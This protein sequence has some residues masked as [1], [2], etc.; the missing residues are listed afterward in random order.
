[1]FRN[2]ADFEKTV[3][4]LNIDSKPN[5]AHRESLRREMLSAFGKNERQPHQQMT[6]LG[7][8]RRTIMKSPIS[9]I[10]AAV[11]IIAVLIGINQFGG[12]VDIATIAFADITEAMQ[13]VTWMRVLPDE[14]IG[15]QALSGEY[16]YSHKNKI[17]ATKDTD[18][19]VEYF[20]LAAQKKYVYKPKT[21]T[22]TIST[23]FSDDDSDIMSRSETPFG[24][25]ETLVETL[26]KLGADVEVEKGKY[27]GTDVYI[28]SMTSTVENTLPFSVVKLFVDQQTH[29][30]LRMEMHLKKA[31]E[32]ADGLHEKP[33][34]MPDRIVSCFEYPENGPKDIY[35]LGVPKTARIVD[36]TISGQTQK[37]LDLYLAC[38]ENL[39]KRYILLITSTNRY[40]DIDQTELSYNDEPRQRYEKI[41]VLDMQKWSKSKGAATAINN[42]N[43]TFDSQFEWWTKTDIAGYGYH[44]YH[45]ELY[46]GQYVHRLSYEYDHQKGLTQG[47]WKT[48]E[49]EYRLEKPNLAKDLTWLGW[50]NHI[51]G[52]HPHEV[53][54][55]IIEDDYS[56]ENKLICVQVLRKGYKHSN[57]PGVSLPG[58]WL[59]YLN[60][61]KNYI[62]QKRLFKY[63]R[64]A[65]WQTDPDWL[66]G[67]DPDKIEKDHYSLTQVLEYGRT[68]SGA[69][70]AKKLRNIYGSGLFENSENQ[71][72]QGRVDTIYLKEA[73]EF[74]EGIFDADT[75]PGH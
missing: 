3:T 47:T 71:Q 28:Q 70:Y 21:D 20:D 34:E 25:A 8:L 14:N 29:L 75:L 2:E 23:F 59:F 11:I 33:P 22:V 74:P 67:V 45:I 31:I 5:P 41:S 46:D 24:A 7:V 10:A 9:K 12:S 40:G 1:M 43:K 52:N 26:E 15:N 50:P 16:W 56:R 48:I 61:E 51:L 73:P 19:S 4:R 35:A 44:L 30:L 42:L 66:D 57:S 37:V 53:S 27:N 32:T 60:P 6:P 36:N 64:D 49:K 38:R 17:R 72:K 13:K 69:W 55:R 54:R 18:G 62:C 39:P 65:T 58:E 63:T 68:E